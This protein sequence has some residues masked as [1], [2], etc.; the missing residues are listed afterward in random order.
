MRGF[1]TAVSWV[2]GLLLV[3]LS[4]FVSL[5]TISRKL[6]AFSFQGADELGGYV[7]AVSSSL[8]FAVALLERGHIRIDFLHDR[9]P[10]RV[11][12]LLNWLAVLSL[13]AF[14][15]FLVRYGFPVIRDTLA[16]N[17][18]AATPWATPLI[19][20]QAI[21]FAALAVFA[22]AGLARAGSA[23]FCLLRGDAAALNRR[24]GPKNAVEELDEELEDLRRR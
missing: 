18:T 16:Y 12:A 3:G 2:F 1:V 21:W 11:Q 14:G 15:V 4:L 13:A 24:F 5:E 23:T 7:L 8:A 9:F 20:P 6:F 17:S 19:Y 10:P 22:L